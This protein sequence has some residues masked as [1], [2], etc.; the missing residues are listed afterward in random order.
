L[1][2]YFNRASS[3]IVFHDELENISRHMP[4]FSVVHVLS[5]P[6]DGWTGE[7]GKLDEQMLRKYVT[8]FDQSV[9]WISG[10]PPMVSAYRSLIEQIGVP[11]D[12]IRTDSFIGY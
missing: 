12:A 9:F 11:D 6:E 5:R 4:T 10:P 2:M 3:D 8:D 1:M 7:R